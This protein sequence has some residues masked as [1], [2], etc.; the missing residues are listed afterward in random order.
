MCESPEVAGI[1]ISNP[2]F[3]STPIIY[4]DDNVPVIQNGKPFLLVGRVMYDSVTEEEIPA[5]NSEVTVTLKDRSGNVVAISDDREKM[6]DDSGNFVLSF[7]AIS[8]KGSYI[9]EIE[10]SDSEYAFTASEEAPFDIGLRNDSDLF[11]K[12]RLKNA[13]PLE[14]TSIT[15]NT[16]RITNLGKTDISI[17]SNRQLFMVTDGVEKLIKEGTVNPLAAGKSQSFAFDYIAPQALPAPLKPFTLRI[18]VD[19]DN[20]VVETDERN[21]T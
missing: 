15:G 2:Q 18:K 10:A 7:E 5:A 16:F 1:Y 14:L 12:I 4:N 17:P 3:I 8:D 21:N 9:A 20:T 19:T 6:T 11:A 13:A